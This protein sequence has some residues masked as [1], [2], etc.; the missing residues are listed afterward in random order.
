MGK[1]CRGFLFLVYRSSP[2][3]TTWTPPSGQPVGMLSHRRI[4]HLNTSDLTDDL[5]RTRWGQTY[6][7]ATCV[8]KI[9]YV[10]CIPNTTYVCTVY[11]GSNTVSG[12]FVHRRQ[13]ICI[14][15]E[16]SSTIQR[17]KKYEKMRS[18]PN[19]K[20]RLW[21]G[22]QESKKVSSNVIPRCDETEYGVPGASAWLPLDAWYGPRVGDMSKSNLWLLF[23][24]SD[25]Y[26]GGISIKEGA[27]YRRDPLS[28]A[29]Q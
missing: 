22:T 23:L 7:I 12:L 4:H 28:K 26:E 10:T 17:R 16:Q 9:S 2:N 24:M 14:Q 18:S 3:L 5:D 21:S 20:R 13:R 29:A 15:L 11:Y 27:I 25:W 6:L 8:V 1:L 19:Q